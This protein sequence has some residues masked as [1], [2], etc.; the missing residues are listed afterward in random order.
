M[1]ATNNALVGPCL[2]VLGPTLLLDPRTGLPLVMRPVVAVL[3]TALALRP[4]EM[5]SVDELCEWI[6]PEEPAGSKNRLFVTVSRARTTLEPFD[7]RI[8][9]DRTPDGYRLDVSPT[10]L[11][12]QSFAR[13]AD[14]TGASTDDP[15]RLHTSTSALAWW[16]G[17]PFASLPDPAPALSQIHLA[18]LSRL[19]LTMQCTTALRDQGQ[20]DAALRLCLRTVADHPEHEPMARLAAELLEVSGEPSAAMR[21]LDDLRRALERDFGATITEESARL[22]RTLVTQQRVP[23]RSAPPQLIGRDE[24][25]CEAIAAMTDHDSV[26]VVEGEPGVGKTSFC[27][28]LLASSSLDFALTRFHEGESSTS[29]RPVRQLINATLLA[30]NSPTKIEITTT[31]ADRDQV[32]GQVLDTLEAELGDAAIAWFLDDTQWADASSLALITYLSTRLRH[33]LPLVISLRSEPLAPHVTEAL[34]AFGRERPVHR[35]RL[36]ELSAAQ[37]TELAAHHGRQLDN[38]TADRFFRLCG[39]NPFVASELLRAPNLHEIPAGLAYSLDSR[40]DSFSPTDRILLDFLALAPSGLSPRILHQLIDVM[41]LSVDPT[42]GLLAHGLRNG[43]VAERHDDAGLRIGL[44]HDLIREHLIRKLSATRGSQLRLELSDAF[45]SVGDVPRSA[46]HAWAAGEAGNPPRAV[47]L[48]VEA[49]NLALQH[50]AFEEVL[51]AVDRAEEAISW[52][53]IEQDTSE[54]WLLRANA[55]H[56]LGDAEGRREAAHACCDIA[57]KNDNHRAFGQAALI[58]G[59]IRSTYGIA[60]SETMVL[61]DEAIGLVGMKE[62]GLRARLLG[63]AGQEAYHVREFD[64]AEQLT[65]AGEALARTLGNNATIALTLEGRIWAQ[66]RPHRLSE[67]M[68]TTVEMVERARYSKNRE[69]ELIARIWRA[70]AWLESGDLALLDAEMPDLVALATDV[71][72]PSHRFRVVTMQATLAILRGR[73]DEGMALAQEAHALGAGIEKDN[74]DQSLAAQLVPWFRDQGMLAAAL[75]MV[76]PMIEEYGDVPGWQCALAFI[77]AETGDLGAARS[78][79]AHLRLNDFASVPDDLAWLMA[80]SFVAEAAYLCDDAQTADIVGRLLTPFASHHAGL[81]DIST[82]G[83]IEFYLGLAAAT[84]GMAGAVNLLQKAHET[85]V[86]MAAPGLAARSASALARLTTPP[87]GSEHVLCPE[88]SL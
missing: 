37:T 42:G 53:G 82:N 1:S 88:T 50:G 35:I 46:F 11:D 45:D 23:R 63:R 56:R 4:G 66:H 36:P 80:M 41:Q 26:I 44:R 72:I 14:G 84:C 48:S 7:G 86:A 16:R 40:L 28:A 64:R 87:A 85:H 19:R 33:R 55:L 32:F 51:T 62:S 74:A 13:I 20:I 5:V 43:L 60:S 15:L 77:L 6:W 58:H 18:E 52:G 83:P 21:V 75:P 8:S 54:L 22:Y 76:A 65:T 73:Y 12:I 9:I 79:L 81:F 59:G 70:C 38:K 2:R 61:L 31:L 3:M 30:I 47:A 34:A 10:D 71:R 69:D 25:L 29:F 24:E 27:E 67:R 39:G 49:A 57:R 78:G 17:K 68:A